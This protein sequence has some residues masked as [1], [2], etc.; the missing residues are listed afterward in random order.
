[1]SF[2]KI[3]VKI[4]DF[5]SIYYFYILNYQ[6][7]TCHLLMFLFMHNQGRLNSILHGILLIISILCGSNTFLFK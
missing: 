2:P 7:Y 6:V 5:Y 1:M 4:R 3:K